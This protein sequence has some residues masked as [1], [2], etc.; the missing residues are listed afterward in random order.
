MK[1]AEWIVLVGILVIAVL[2][3]ARAPTPQ[4]VE[5][6]VTKEVEKIVTNRP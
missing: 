6:V 3:Q 2:V 4:G 5:Q 1:G